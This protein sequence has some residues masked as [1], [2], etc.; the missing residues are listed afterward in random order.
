ME[1]RK[2]PPGDRDMPITEHLA[3]LRKRI[4]IV[5]SAVLVATMAAFP[6]SGAII[7]R[8]W[9]DILPTG[10][11]MTVYGPLEFLMARIGISIVV[12]LLLGVPLMVYE[13]IAFMAPGLYPEEQRFMKVVFPASMLLF[14]GGAALAYYVALPLMFYVLV[15]HSGDVAV[16]AMSVGRTL[17]SIITVIAGFGVLFQ[18]PLLL[19]FLTYTGLVS[20]EFLREKRIFAYLLLATFAL[21]IAPD[22]T[23]IS[24]LLVAA[25][26]VILFEVS[27]LISRVLLRRKQA[28]DN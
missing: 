2:G 8:L 4:I 14:L 28:R 13:A 27:L 5:F 20:E 16:P 15:M 11:D 12:A 6:F 24:Q 17:S 9:T 19:V 26:L 3:E 23:A 18:L 7:N 1:E 22:P 21:F 25:C 10:I